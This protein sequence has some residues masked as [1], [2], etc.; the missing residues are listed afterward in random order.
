VLPN[1][2]FVILQSVANQETMPGEHLTSSTSA[3]KKSKRQRKYRVVNHSH[4]R[5]SSRQLC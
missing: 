1:T 5:T 3:E 4:K 2:N